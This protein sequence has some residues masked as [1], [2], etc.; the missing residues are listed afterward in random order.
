LCPCSSH[1]VEDFTASLRVYRTSHI[2]SLDEAE[3][4]YQEGAE[5]LIIGAG[6]YGNVVLSNEAKTYFERKRCRVNLL[7]TPEAIGVWNKAL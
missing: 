4:V 2:I 3:Q 6:Q 1:G 5:Q 7:P